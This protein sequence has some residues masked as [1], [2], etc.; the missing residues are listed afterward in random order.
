MT[1][2]DYIALAA[3]IKTARDSLLPDN[4]DG[5]G[6][7]RECALQIA[8]ACKRDNTNFKHGLFLQACGF[9]A[10]STSRSARDQL[11]PHLKGQP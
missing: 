5:R 3:A 1:R 6:A 7:V 8:A 9:G 11:Q 4:H 2:K 10:D